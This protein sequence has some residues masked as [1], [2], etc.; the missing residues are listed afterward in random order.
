MRTDCYRFRLAAVEG[1]VTSPLVG[2]ILDLLIFCA[3][4]TIRVYL[5]LDPQEESIR[6]ES[7]VTHRASTSPISPSKI[8]L[9]A[10]IYPI[11]PQLRISALLL[12]ATVVVGVVADIQ[13]S[14]CAVA[15]RVCAPFGLRVRGCDRVMRDRVDSESRSVWDYPYPSP[16]PAKSPTQ[17]Q[18]TNK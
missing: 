16:R 8:D 4:G 5:G 17:S 15:V 13:P 2:H 3:G 18:R 12:W 7:V 10:S 14:S 6:C 9:W 1:L 11:S